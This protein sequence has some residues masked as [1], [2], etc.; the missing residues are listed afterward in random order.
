MERMKIVKVACVGDEVGV[1][2]CAAATATAAETMPARVSAYPRLEWSE[3]MS[4]HS[5][6]H[7][8]RA[9]M[10]LV[11]RSDR[12]WLV[13]S[14]NDRRSYLQGLLTN[15]IEALGAGRGC[16]A[17]YLTPQGRMI[18]DLWV[19]ELGDVI[20]LSMSR[21]VKA[22]VLARLDQ[23]VFTEEVQLG[24]V[25]ETFAAVAI[26]G[27]RSANAV[28]A[29]TGLA[30]DTIAA[31]PE[32]G[33][34]RADFRGKPA[35]VVRTTDTGLNGFDLLVDAAQ[36]DEAIDLF[37]ASGAV[38][39]D[40]VAADALRIEAG[41]AKFH[42]DMNEETIPLEAG[43]EGRAISQTKGC[44]VGQE[45][46]I[47][48][49]HRG[50][51]RVARRL[52]GLSLEGGAAPAAGA[53]VHVDGKQVGSVT[54]AAY[55]PALDRPIALGYVQRDHAEPGTAVTVDGVAAVVTATPFTPLD[56]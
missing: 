45:V 39:L 44:Y 32:H 19:Y 37:R 21:D 7:A 3:G 5:S 8:A 47:R 11:D 33:N 18:T 16:Y 40:A 49:L 42:R 28:A 24:D 22:A 43:I 56:R 1:G 10:A 36:R 30:A 48:V 9:A 2:C 25:S 35:V 31:L 55:S 13:V 34:L 38:D 15:D 27:P 20:L 54:S 17:A 51:G 6:Y 12:A 50:H 4:Q 14:G 26:V 23:F 29:A 52:V 41:I 53:A 46:I